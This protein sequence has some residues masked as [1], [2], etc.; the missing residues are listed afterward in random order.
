M[1]EKI[2]LLTEKL[3]NALDNDYRFLQLKEIEEKMNN[4]EEVMKLAYQKDTKNN[5]YNDL[6]K[7]YDDSHPLVIEARKELVEAKTKLESYP[8][9]KQYLK[10]YIEVRDV[11]YK[12]N[13]IL[14]S[15]LKGKRY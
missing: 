14:F 13:D 12:I 8:I 4:D 7:I 15:D 5:R 10:A 2:Y 3:K 11:L 9:V 1:D 6:L